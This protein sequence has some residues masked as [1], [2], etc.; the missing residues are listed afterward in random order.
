MEIVQLAAVNTLVKAEFLS[1][2]ALKKG[3]MNFSV[4]PVPEKIEAPAKGHNDQEAT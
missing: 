1:E 4:A 3:Q 2:D